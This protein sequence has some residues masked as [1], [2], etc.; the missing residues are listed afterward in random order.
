MYIRTKVFVCCLLFGVHCLVRWYFFKFSFLKFNLRIVVLHLLG[1][2]NACDA[3]TRAIL[4]L[5]FNVK[6]FVVIFMFL[7]LV[8]FLNSSLLSSICNHWSIFASMF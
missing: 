3:F 6:F 5:H 2:N 4:A 7:L 8:N 1:M